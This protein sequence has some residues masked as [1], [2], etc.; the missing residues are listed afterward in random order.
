M[1]SCS[2]RP[3]SL[4]SIHNN[5]KPCRQ[6][7]KEVT[8]DLKVFSR[9]IPFQHLGREKDVRVFIAR[10]LEPG[11]AAPFTVAMAAQQLEQQKAAAAAKLAAKSAAVT[12]VCA[13]LGRGI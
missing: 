4:F 6:L 9:I 1:L 3:F 8:D 2:C 11:E 7:G 10:T 13:V 12:E 5:A